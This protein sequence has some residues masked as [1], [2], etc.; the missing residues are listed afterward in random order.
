MCVAA[1]FINI[2]DFLIKHYFYHDAI[3]D[4]I[5]VAKKHGKTE[6]AE[7]LTQKAAGR[8]PVVPSVENPIASENDERNHDKAIDNQTSQDSS[9]NKDR[10]SDDLLLPLCDRQMDPRHLLEDSKLEVEE[11][12]AVDE[13]PS[14]V[15]VSNVKE[16]TAV[17]ETLF[18]VEVSNVKEP[19]VVDKVLLE[20]EVG[21]V[22]E[23]T[24]VDK[25][26]FEVEVGNVKDPTAVDKM[27]P[28]FEVDNVPF[29]ILTATDEM[30]SEVEVSEIKEATAVDEVPVEIEGGK[31][32]DLS[33]SAIISV[34]DVSVNDFIPLCD[35]SEL[36]IVRPS[37]VLQKIKEFELIN[38]AL[39]APISPPKGKEK[40]AWPRSPPQQLQQSPVISSRASIIEGSTEDVIGN[41]A[42]KFE[43]CNHSLCVSVSTM[44][45]KETYI[46]FLDC[47]RFEHEMREE[48]K[49]QDNQAADHIRRERIKGKESPA[50]EHKNMVELFLEDPEELD[51]SVTTAASARVS[52][53]TSSHATTSQTDKG[54]HGDNKNS[55][56]TAVPNIDEPYYL[57]SS[58]SA[59]LDKIVQPEDKDEHSF[60]EADENNSGSTA[61]NFSPQL[62]AEKDL[63]SGRDIMSVAH[64]FLSADDDE[65]Q[66][67]EEEEKEVIQEEEVVHMMPLHRDSAT[68]HSINQLVNYSPDHSRLNVGAKF[69]A[70]EPALSKE[71]SSL[72]SG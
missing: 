15:E 48:E 8:D 25:V 40:H 36:E 70:V 12:T 51:K 13:V 7:F 29:E 24:T 23:P 1:G 62:S 61:S 5:R 19:T 34:C 72:S 46:N 31:V 35:I 26:L 49:R 27:V 71:Y 17:D 30:L 55:N 9:P 33:E 32:V 42:E 4:A 52:S 37:S 65:S 11:A 63:N 45:P 10:S 41:A 50:E 16:A 53:S 57:F 28:E 14:K 3:I 68:Q 21:N 44:S 39:S 38:A 47:E 56:D 43:D 20:V 2:A 54:T 67:S 66:S 69:E 60:D 18:E 22:K 6:M 58:L 59:K 64:L